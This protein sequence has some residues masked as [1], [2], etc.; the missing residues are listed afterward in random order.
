MEEY[1][2][3]KEQQLRWFLG[4]PTP[5]YDKERTPSPVAET[6]R[7]AKR[8]PPRKVKRV[9]KATKKKILESHL[10]QKENLPARDQWAFL[11]WKDPN[12][13]KKKPFGGFARKNS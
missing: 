9:S 2:Q 7:Q 3:M 1:D 13:K 5:P 11:S 12:K 4:P 6:K 8:D 10:A